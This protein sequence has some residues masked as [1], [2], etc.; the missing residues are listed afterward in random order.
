MSEQTPAPTSE[1][2]PSDSGSTLGDAGKKAL[3]AERTRA[4][5]AEKRLR[6]VETSLQSVQTAHEESLKELQEQLTTGTALAEQAVAERDR[7]QVAYTKGL[8]AD[9]VEFLQGS[10]A[11]ELAVSADKLME[12]VAPKNVMQPDP[13]Q[14]ASGKEAPADPRRELLSQIFNKSS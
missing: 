12:H 3:Q 5:Q 14:G 8:P 9:L 13:L 4:D 1:Q 10:N 6:E 7:Y 2:A 11:E